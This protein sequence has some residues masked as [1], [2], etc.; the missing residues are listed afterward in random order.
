ML[1]AGESNSGRA[2]AFTPSWKCGHLGGM[3][4]LA[5]RYWDVSTRLRIRLENVK[6]H[7]VK[8]P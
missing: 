4:T 5:V 3:P 8:D 7:G 6:P 1:I 2:I